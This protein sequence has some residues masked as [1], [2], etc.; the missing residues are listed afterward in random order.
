MGS[1]KVAVV[2]LIAMIIMFGTVDNGE[3][4]RISDVKDGKVIGINE[5]KNCTWESYRCYKLCIKGCVNE[6]HPAEESNKLKSE[7][8]CKP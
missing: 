6:K 1:I 2:I 8:C 3:A 7:L 5:N 4:I